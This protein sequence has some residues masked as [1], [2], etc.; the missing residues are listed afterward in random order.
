MSW[1]Q[2]RRGEARRGEARRGKPSASIDS[3]AE[4]N[5]PAT[6][7]SWP[8]GPLCRP[9]QRSLGT[10]RASVVAVGA[11]PC[12]PRQRSERR[13]RS[14]QK[15]EEEAH[16]PPGPWLRRPRNGGSLSGAAA[17]PPGERRSRWRLTHPGRR[18]S[19]PWTSTRL[20]RRR[21]RW[22]WTRLRQGCW[23]TRAAWAGCPQRRGARSA[24]GRPGALPEPPS[25]R[26]GTSGAAPAAATS[27]LRG[28]GRDGMG[29]AGA[30]AAL[31]PQVSPA[32][33]PAA[34]AL[35]PGHLLCPGA[36]GRG[37]ESRCHLL[38]GSPRAPG[39]VLRSPHRRPGHPRA[40]LEQE[41]AFQGKEAR[42]RAP[43]T[44]GDQRPLLENIVG[45]QRTAWDLHLAFKR[46]KVWRQN[47]TSW[48]QDFPKRS[49][50]P[51]RSDRSEAFGPSPKSRRWLQR[52]VG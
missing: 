7:P 48:K 13:G 12:Q 25:R 39:G 11:E 44:A 29:R 32:S 43:E 49:C 42:W 30:A 41:L 27:R 1:F 10:P 28:M 5:G 18:R 14:E 21:S 50:P 26:L 20:G 6:G 9:P 15:K 22:T 16:G 2:P 3:T 38:V 31:E 47:L 33:Q 8:C 19:S 35:M 4:Q 17:P 23:G 46:G 45:D 52:K 51:A 24:A 34:P 37:E 36:W 40:A